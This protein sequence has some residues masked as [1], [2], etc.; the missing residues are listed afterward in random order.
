[1]GLVVAN[2]VVDMYAKC[3]SLALA[4]QTFERMRQRSVVSWNSLIMG[5]A[6][7]GQAHVALRLFGQMRNQGFLPDARTLLAALKAC[8]ALLLEDTSKG[9]K[10]M[11]A[12]E[13][14]RAV[15]SLVSKSG[16]EADVFV[17]SALVD[18]FSRG[19]E[20]AEAR[21]I[22]ER[23]VNRD[24][25]LWNAMIGAYARSDEASDWH[26]ALEMVE[27]MQRCGGVQANAATFVAALGACI[28]LATTEQGCYQLDGG[29]GNARLVKT[30]ALEK[31]RALHARIVES[32]HVLD[33][34]V[35]NSL[36]DMY[37]KCG[38]LTD[39][40]SV[41]DKVVHRDTVL[42]NSM[43]MAYSRNGHGDKCLEAFSAMKEESCEPDARTFVAV[44]K[45]CACEEHKAGSVDKR[46]GIHS[47]LVRRGVEADVYVASTLLEMYSACGRLDDAFQ[48]FDS[49]PS[50]DQV[51]WNAMI[52][53]CASCG[54]G[55]ASHILFQRMQDEGYLPG[56]GTFAAVLNG[57]A[58]SSG[59]SK[60]ELLKRV[61][62]I[63]SRLSKSTEGAGLLGSTLIDA[64]ARC[65]AF[66]E[67][68]QVFEA[69]PR[70]HRDIGSWNALVL[71]YVDNGD[72]RSALDAFA[73]M[74]AEGVLP[75]ARTFAAVLKACGSIGDLERGRGIQTEIR[76]AG[77]DNDGTLGSSMVGFFAKCGSIADGREVF[78]KLQVRD[79]S[80]WN[81][82][83][84]GYAQA[85]DGGEALSLFRR[86]QD[87]GFT[88]SSRTFM[89]AL[90]ACSCGASKAGPGGGEDVKACYLE[91]VRGLHS[92]L[93]DNGP[94][95]DAFL[96]SSLID[97]YSKCGSTR[98]A[99]EVFDRMPERN[100]NLV[101]WNAI[102]LGCAHNG[103]PD[104]A[105]QLF[106][107]MK[108]QGVRPDA[109]TYAGALQACGSKGDLEA[110]RT[111]SDEVRG[112]GLMEEKNVL[113]ASSLIS[114]FGKCGS[115]V[116]A[117]HIF[118]SSAAFL[119]KESVAW[120][121]LMTGYSHQGDAQ[122]VFGL[123]DDMLERRL[124][125]DGFTF[126]SLLTACGRAGLVDQGKHYF[127]LM[128]SPRFSIAPWYEHYSCMVDLL[129]R[130]N[131]LEEAA[132]LAM[133]MPV[134]GLSVWKSL[135]ASCQRWKNV[136][137]AK[138]AFEAIQ[139]LDDRDSAAYVLMANT[140]ASG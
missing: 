109:L 95:L 105:M 29:G 34:F 14:G 47:Q 76:S 16:L 21:R 51:L 55:D 73:R 139:K 52:Q 24:V 49:M 53:G 121:S 112:S 107:R 10:K 103:E 19:G 37:S 129:G 106:S 5:C 66:D 79:V 132:A 91:E 13:H 123:F 81:A 119:A 118:D 2:S 94:E 82:M 122:R 22:F 134:K 120:N 113:V 130:S 97:A 135:L 1:M 110:G 83:I 8:T 65:G 59:R 99:L 75:N 60:P 45:A 67:A 84:S 138:V 3:G 90:S 98:E 35:A 104:C 63:H 61:R 72:A 92:Q 33:V 128:A 69:M 96:G 11:M 100:V 68:R 133:E 126:L 71:G 25:V 116:D 88:P 102:I 137:A 38:A 31:G 117:Q 23:T 57:C 114:F 6:R 89:A 18:L 74:K 9:Q 136:E 50:H 40:R 15:H 101:T 140:Y 27:R 30:A 7:G 20:L 56:S 85:G 42:W 46:R 32:G 124:Q 78:D 54:H 108:R 111:I 43:L 93:V 80:C 41:F 39:A 86:M 115:M 17:A 4:R 26:T 48:V 64:Y 62:D 36:V 70:Q 125:V 77:L 58:N 127:Q 12:M 44:L 87:E 131:R 28:S